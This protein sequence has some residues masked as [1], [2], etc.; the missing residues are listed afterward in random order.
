[1]QTRFLNYSIFLLVL[2]AVN[3]AG[4]Q[5]KTEKKKTT[6]TGYRINNVDGKNRETITTEVDGSGY[7]LEF[8]NDKLTE[9]WVD[10]NLVPADQYNKYG[11]VIRKLKEQMRLDKIQAKKDQE[12]ATK[13]QVQAKKD[14]QQAKRDEEQAMKE[15]QLAKLDMERAQKDQHQAKLDQEQASKDQVQAKLDKEASEKDQ[16]QAK[17]DQEQAIKDQVQ[18]KL[19]QEQAMRDQGQAKLDQK[20]AEEDQR[21]MKQLVSD[22]IKDGIVGDEKSLVSVELTPEG[23]KVNGKKQPDEVFAKYKQRYIRFAT[24]EFFYSNSPNGKSIQMH[25]IKDK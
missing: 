19:D 13:D 4:A 3:T 20:Q 2:M 25:R 8:L 17:L 5:Q 22:L 23:M 1:M 24:G 16:Q 12:Q 9:L 15:Q 10:G 14:M 6:S 18:A 11:L 21:L 7:K